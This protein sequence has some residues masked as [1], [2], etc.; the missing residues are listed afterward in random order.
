MPQL[1]VHDILMKF[2]LVILFITLYSKT[3][4]EESR[5]KDIKYKVTQEHLRE[6]WFWLY[7]W[8]ISW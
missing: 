6:M 2:L 7:K 8:Q 5:N 4:Q 3:E 1:F